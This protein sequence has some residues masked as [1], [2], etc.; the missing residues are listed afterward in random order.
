MGKHSKLSRDSKITK[1]NMN[2]RNSM[3][4]GKIK[5]LERQFL[6]R[7]DNSVK[8]IDISKIS[9]SARAPLMSTP[10]TFNLSHI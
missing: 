6:N 5:N 4:A 10:K 3:Q 2:V 1:T 8:N 7:I 9:A